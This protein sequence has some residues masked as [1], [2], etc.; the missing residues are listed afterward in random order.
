LKKF[1]G[2]HMKNKLKL[3]LIIFL[4]LLFS[5]T[6]MSVIYVA[7]YMDIQTNPTKLLH[8]I[9]M[10]KEDKTTLLVALNVVFTIALS[11]YS[12]VNLYLSFYKGDSKG[13]SKGV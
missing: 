4:S 5:L 3:S 9:T 11:L 8:V 13:V 6:I 10:T 12:F 1:K 2:N 7:T